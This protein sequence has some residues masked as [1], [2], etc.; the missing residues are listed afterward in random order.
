MVP[1]T[2]STG[3]LSSDYHESRGIF[4]VLSFSGPLFN[5]QLVRVF[6]TLSI[7]LS[8]RVASIPVQLVEVPL[9]DMQWSGSVLAKQW[10][11]RCA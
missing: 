5:N 11:A 3:M 6:R 9:D 8:P 4:H 10:H 2:F 1:R 7:N